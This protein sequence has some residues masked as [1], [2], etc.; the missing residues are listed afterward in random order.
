MIDSTHSTQK[1]SS[2][3]KRH[4]KQ[5]RAHPLF[6]DVLRLYSL[7][8]RPII[9]SIPPL[10]VLAGLSSRRLNKTST[11]FDSKHP[12]RVTYFA[13]PQAS[14]EVLFKEFSDE[15]HPLLKDASH[16]SSEVAFIITYN[17]RVSSTE[18]PDLI[19]KVYREGTVLACTCSLGARFAKAG[20]CCVTRII[21]PV[22]SQTLCQ[23]WQMLRDPI[24][25]LMSTE[26]FTDK[27]T[28]SR[29]HT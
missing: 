23:N 1:P 12:D 19:L 27:L 3:P 10:E 29:C 2:A 20:R 24:I 8:K 16:T 18:T 4:R 28:L 5:M 7:C 26:S 13:L 22:A 17:A 14:E 25:F 15:D 21:V 11:N 6:R 9:G